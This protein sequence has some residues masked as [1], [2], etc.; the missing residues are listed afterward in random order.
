[1]NF[2]F[3]LH[4]VYKSVIAIFIIF[5]LNQLNRILKAEIRNVNLALILI[6][7]FDYFKFFFGH[8]CWIFAFC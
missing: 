7:L 1:M 8:L 6:N 3:T 2:L 5:Y 4:L